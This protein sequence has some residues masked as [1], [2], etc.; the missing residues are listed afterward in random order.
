MRLLLALSI[1]SWSTAKASTCSNFTLFNAT[2]ST[3]IP[4]P[5]INDTYPTSQWTLSNFISESPN[6][7]A[8]HVSTVRHTFE[9]QTSPY[10][11]FSDPSFPI[12]GCFIFV[13]TFPRSY[14]NGIYD[15]GTCSS[16]LDP[17]CLAELITTINSTASSISRSTN[18]TEEASCLSLQ[19]KMRDIDDRDS[20]SKCS[21][22]WGILDYTFLSA[23]KSAYFPTSDPACTTVDVN[24]ANSTAIFQ[25]SWTSFGAEEGNYTAYD[26]ALR[27]PTPMIVTTWAKSGNSGWADTKIMCV[28]ANQTITAGSRDVDAASAS[29]SGISTSTPSSTSTSSSS[30]ATTSKTSGAV[31]TFGAGAHFA[32]AVVLVFG[33][34]I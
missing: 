27:V 8:P 10:Q 2:G 29:A 11:N 30:S 32:L 19:Q 4:G 34:T 20:G 26:T 18:A 23:P 25:D 5:R 13:M 9:L 6:P 24:T 1:L 14:A 31:S 21:S 28:P 16:V 33:L 22:H 17:D 15:D 7:D 12:T 3:T